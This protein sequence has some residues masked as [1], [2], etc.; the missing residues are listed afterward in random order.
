[1]EFAFFF[2]DERKYFYKNSQRIARLVEIGTSDSLDKFSIRWS[3]R[4]RNK[5]KLV[6]CKFIPKY[7]QQASREL[8]PL[9]K[10]KNKMGEVK[11]EAF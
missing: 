10:N 1:M 6:M 2:R 11:E 7:S 4:W 8:L 5:V 3:L 9:L